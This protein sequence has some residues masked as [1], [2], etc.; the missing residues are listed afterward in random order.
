M[1]FGTL[2]HFNTY[3]CNIMG[4]FAPWIPVTLLGIE[5]AVRARR[6]VP[7]LASLG[8]AGLGVSQVLAAWLGQGTFYAVFLVGGY[9][10]YRTVLSPPRRPEGWDSRTAGVCS[11]AC[12][13]SAGVVR[14]RACVS[15][16]RD[17]SPAPDIS[18][19]STL[20]G[21]DYRALGVKADPGMPALPGAQ[22]AA[23]FRQFVARRVYVGTGVM[24]LAILAPFFARRHLAVPFFATSDAHWL[25]SH[26][27]DG[28]RSTNCFFLI[29]Q[30]ETLHTTATTGSSARCRP[31][32]PMLAAAT[33][34]AML[35]VRVRW[36]SAATVLIPALCYLLRPRVSRLK[37]THS[38]SLAGLDGSADSPSSSS[39]CFLLLRLDRIGRQLRPFRP[40]TG[41]VLC[42]IIVLLRRGP[43]G[44][45]RLQDRL[46]Q[47]HPHRL[48]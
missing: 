33:V 30:F 4:N 26:P 12:S 3:C 10:L 47:Q 16:Q 37:V 43:D 18:R 22:H 2:I 29:L 6:W 9:V 31:G 36:P 45:R 21:G 40:L 32:P 24:L 38:L 13:V 48:Q 7:R 34:E 41:L 17:C 28:R 27:E 35:R 14:R 25:A 15:R 1:G 8:L 42:A 39:E 20:S 44:N 11:I 5:L 19:Y 46:G 23:G